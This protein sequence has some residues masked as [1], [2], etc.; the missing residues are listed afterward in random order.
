MN[1]LD[2]FAGVG[3]FALGAHMAGM[4]FD[5]HYFSEVD[6]WAVDLYQ[7]RFPASIPL[8]DIRGIR[9]LPRG[10]WLITGGFP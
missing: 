3:G 8:G 6:P 2:L 5:A 9:D 1:Y 4:K 10:E 7:K